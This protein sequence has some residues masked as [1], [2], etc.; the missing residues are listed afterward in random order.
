MP[1]LRRLHCCCLRGLPGHLLRAQVGINVHA[2]LRI[3]R[4]RHSSHC[5]LLLDAWHRC[6]ARCCC[7]V[8]C[9][10]G[11]L[12]LID[13]SCVGCGTGLHCRWLLHDGWLVRRLP[14]QRQ[15][16]VERRCQAGAKASLAVAARKAAHGMCRGRL[17]LGGSLQGG[18][19]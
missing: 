2:M 5:L 9:R 13:I 4:L 14:W 19:G 8:A 17:A 11:W 6:R 3:L 16:R 1:R 12:L 15:G 10:H 18:T 7:A